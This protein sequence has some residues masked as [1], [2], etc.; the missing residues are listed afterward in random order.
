MLKRI[1]TAVCLLAV[2]FGSLF[3]LRQIN[4][5]FADI[6]GLLVCSIGV[7]EM[8]H[9]FKKAGYKPIIIPLIITALAIFPA[10]YFLAE[11]AILFVLITVTL[12]SIIIFTLVHKYEL[13]DLL[14]TLFIAIYPAILFA[15]FFIINHSEYGMLAILLGLFIPILTDTMAYFVGVTF[16][17]KKMCPKIS[18][19][20]TI[21]GGI[22]GLIGGVMGAMLVFTLFDCFAVFKNMDNVG[23]LALTSNF[24]ISVVIYVLFGL[25]GAI[26]SILGDLGASWIK[27]KAEIKDFGKIFPGHGG[28][29][30]RLD[31]IL[32]MMPLVYMLIVVLQLVGA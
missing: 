18:P 29:M 11:T 4:V 32:F 28:M 13:K 16:K 19:K 27:R 2:V 12:L 9:A 23:K 15:T 6:I 1:I 20:K 10:T 5:L 31:S 17:G 22:G 14:A 30:D 8:Y 7:F 26:L 3:G 25:F 24:N 21:S